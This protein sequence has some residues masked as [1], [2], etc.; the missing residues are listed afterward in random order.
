VSVD[1]DP[2]Y[3]VGVGRAVG[4]VKTLSRTTLI[5]VYQCIFFPL[6]RPVLQ[7]LTMQDQAQRDASSIGP[8]DED[9]SCSL[10]L[11]FLVSYLP[12]T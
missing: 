11:F 2:S 8:G 12:E 1:L 3:G 7:E 4:N 5:L 10:L 6:S 9:H